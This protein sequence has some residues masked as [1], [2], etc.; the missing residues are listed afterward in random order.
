MAEE[1]KKPAGVLCWTGGPTHATLGGGN[2]KNGGENNVSDQ[3]TKSAASVHDLDPSMLKVWEWRRATTTM[4]RKCVCVCASISSTAA[5]L[6][7]QGCVRVEAM[8]YC[9]T[10]G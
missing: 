8:E 7:R 2:D 9:V 1:D 6:E 3:Q 5:P 10:R 4:P